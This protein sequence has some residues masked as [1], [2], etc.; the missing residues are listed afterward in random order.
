[1]DLDQK[2]LLDSTGLV[3]SGLVDSKEGENRISTSSSHWTYLLALDLA[4]SLDLAA[5]LN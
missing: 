1:M 3:D 2:I 4:G 5:G